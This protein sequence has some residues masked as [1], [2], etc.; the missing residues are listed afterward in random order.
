L[1]SLR[2][3]AILESKNSS[4]PEK[5]TRVM[6]FPDVPRV[7]FKVNT[8]EEVT[9]QLRFPPILKID[10]QSPVAFQERVRAGYPFYKAGSNVQMGLNLSPDIARLLRP[11]FPLLSAYQ[12]HEFGSKDAQWT[13]ALTREFLALTCKQYEQWETFRARLNDPLQAL[14]DLYSPSF[15]VRIRLRYKNLIRRSR[16]NLDQADWSELLNPC[17]VGAYSSSDIRTEIDTHSLQMLIRLQDNKGR[18]LVSCGVVRPGPTDEE[19]FLIDADF[20][21]D[22]PTETTHALNQLDFLN[23]QSDRFFRWC[24]REPI[25]DALLGSRPV[26]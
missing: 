7:I 12:T 1:T 10:A 24:I 3:S 23:N 2:I 5:G 26:S 4:C 17:I 18:A 19:C 16:L 21:I 15:F 13:L 9:C 14:I 25:H 11:D 20:F 6:P 8:L 22:P